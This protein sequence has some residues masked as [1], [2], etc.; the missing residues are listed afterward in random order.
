MRAWLALIAIVGGA[1]GGCN[2]APATWH[3]RD[4]FLRA[5]DDR[6]VILRGVN[7]SGAQKL[8]PYL[9]D[10]ELADYQ[11][12]H[13]AWGFD[14]IRF[15]MTWAA[16]EPTEGVYDDDYLDGVIERIRW[17]DTS[18]LSVIVEMHEDI[19]GEGF[20]FDGAPRWT[21][22]EAYYAAFVPLTPWFIN[23][24]D[25]NVTACV[26]QFYTNA[27]R[28]QHFIDAWQHVA[29]RLAHEPPVIG[30]DILNE[31]NW[32]TYPL[33][34]F[35]HDRLTPLYIDV[36]AAVRAQAPNWI[37]F[38]E[39]SA[40]RNGGIA[41]KLTAMPFANVMYA[42]HAYDSG[43]EGGSGY[44]PTHRQDVLDNGT[45]LAGEAHTLDAGLWIGEYG[46]D[47]A[48]PNIGAYMTDEYD[49]A[50]QVAGSTMYWAYDNSDGY[51]LVNPDGS[52]KPD[53]VTA[54]V[55]PYPELTAGDPTSY[56]FD[57]TTSTFTFVYTPD[58]ASTSATEIVVPDRVYPAGYQVDCGDCTYVTA[59]GRL[60]ISAPPSA[61]PAT[62]V[63]H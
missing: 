35:E 42:P 29:A 30:F 63:V 57:P 41:T 51:G 17:A 48:D 28:R 11:R 8:A 18:G 21:C 59:P 40:S 39:P 2:A 12:A 54:V 46:G 20:G 37:A 44:D 61:S 27:D 58:R 16:V 14:A 55:R 33:F 49:A 5:A 34:Q 53:L 56:A 1:V 50:A 22:D 31:P 47:G 9:D 23:S 6:A 19:Y 32:G 38:V 4:G 15:I 24:E 45:A 62:I 3:V 13:D 60:I 10:K 7:L 36:V 26:D 25:P 52:E 43:A